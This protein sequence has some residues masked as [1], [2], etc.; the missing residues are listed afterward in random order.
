[1]TEFVEDLD[2]NVL[3]L[4]DRIMIVGNIYMSAHELC[5]C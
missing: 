4:T 1:M 2:E 3:S 5:V